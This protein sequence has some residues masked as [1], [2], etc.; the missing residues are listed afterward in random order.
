M[1][2]F[3]YIIVKLYSISHGYK[4][5]KSVMAI[6]AVQQIL[7]T[8]TFVSPAPE[9]YQNTDILGTNVLSHLDEQTVQGRCIQYNYLRVCV[10]MCVGG[11]GGGGGGL[12]KP[13]SKTSLFASFSV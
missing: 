10:Y 7:N 4:G 8:R 5:L 1:P 3:S 13:L 2:H 6:V 11:K 12:G 9:F